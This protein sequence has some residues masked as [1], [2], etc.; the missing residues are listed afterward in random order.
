MKFCC[1]AVI[2]SSA[3]VI[4]FAGAGGTPRKE[5]VPKYLKMLLKA[6]S[7]KDRALA[8]DMLGKRG[9]VKAPDVADAI[10]PLQKALQKDIDASVRAAAAKALGNI[11]SDPEGTVPLLIEALKDKGTDVKFNSIVSLGQYGPDAKDALPALREFLGKKDDKI[12]SQAA[13]TAIGNI[14]GKKKK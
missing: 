10:E 8:A 11:G 12:T 1:A 2:L 7:A 5:D 13:K 4:G 6:Q 14:T 9:A 3:A